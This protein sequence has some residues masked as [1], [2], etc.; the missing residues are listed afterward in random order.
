MTWTAPDVVR[1]EEPIIAGERTMPEGR[2]SADVER[3]WFRR[4]M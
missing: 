2:H 4:H 1:A 3:S